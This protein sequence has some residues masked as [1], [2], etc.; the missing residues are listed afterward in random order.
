MTG[1]GCPTRRRTTRPR[2]QVLERLARP[3]GD[4]PHV[5]SRRDKLAKFLEDADLDEANP[6]LGL[7]SIRLCLSELGKRAVPRAAARPAARVGAR[8]AQAHV[9][10]DLGRRR[11]ARGQGGRRRGQGR[12]ARARAS[13]ST[14]TQARH[15]DRDAVGG[16]DRRPARAG[17]RLLLDRHERPHPVHDGGRSRERVR[18]VPVRAAAPVAAA[19]DRRRRDGGAAPRASRSRCAAR[20]RASR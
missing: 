6:A 2:S 4:D 17:V 11:A 12:A 10:D 14:R 16:A 3:A 19:A 7:R 13:R 8:P 18:V 1:D 5:R 20:W 15:H 9:P